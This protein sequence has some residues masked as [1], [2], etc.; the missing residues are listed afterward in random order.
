VPGGWTRLHN[1][2]VHNLNFSL[3]IFRVTKSRKIILAGQE[4]R[5]A[6]KI[7]VEN[8]KGRDHSEDLGGNRD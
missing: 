7:L 8:V 1:E 3:S 4:K 5:N 2:E 6:Y